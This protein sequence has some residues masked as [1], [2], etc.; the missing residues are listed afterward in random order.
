MCVSLAVSFMRFSV[1]FYSGFRSGCEKCLQAGVGWFTLNKMK[2]IVIMFLVCI[3]L[4][5]GAVNGLA[6]TAD[7]EQETKNSTDSF[8]HG[9]EDALRTHKAVG[10]IVFGLIGGSTLGLIGVGCVVFI[11]LLA[12]AS[13]EFIP[14]GVDSAAY[15][16]GFRFEGRRINIRKAYRGSIIGWGIRGGLFL[17]SAI[18]N[19]YP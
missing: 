13:P 5:V 6:A 8:G 19:P 15:E 2:S 17:I 9:V 14:E 10:W 12:D 1:Y 4:S 16:E 7:T 18:L 3:F 11:S